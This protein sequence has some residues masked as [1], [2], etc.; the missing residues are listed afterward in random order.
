[1][2]RTSDA[3]FHIG[4]LNQC[5]FISNQL[6]FRKQPFYPATKFKNEVS[7]LNINQYASLKK[8]HLYNVNV[9]ELTNQAK[10]IAC[11][12]CDK[13][14]ITLLEEYIDKKN[15]KAINLQHIDVYSSQHQIIN[16]E[17]DQENDRI[18]GNPIIRHPK[19]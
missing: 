7:K 14:F 3:Q 13:F 6:D 8:Q 11:K 5:W 12:S 18:I 19:G 10:Q 1:M 16:E 17:V 9:R 15:W 4:F 2:L